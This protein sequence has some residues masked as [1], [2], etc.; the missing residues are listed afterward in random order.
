MSL[1]C[2]VTIGV[3]HLLVDKVGRVAAVAGQAAV[4]GGL[5]QVAQ[6][7][8]HVVV[9]SLA[10]GAAAARLVGLHGYSVTWG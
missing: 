8:A 7:S 4:C 5:G 10:V 2:D 1:T 9:A 3:C 6:V